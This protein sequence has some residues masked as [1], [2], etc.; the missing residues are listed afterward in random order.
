M[1]GKPMNIPD[2]GDALPGRSTPMG[3]PEKHFVHDAPLTP[4]FPEG[5]AVGYFAIG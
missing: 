2:P 1:L 3:V 5:T 4:P